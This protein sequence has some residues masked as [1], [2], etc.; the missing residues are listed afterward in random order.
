MYIV[1]HT[2]YMYNDYIKIN[3]IW[4]MYMYNHSTLPAM[5][6]HPRTI[7]VLPKILTVVVGF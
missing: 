7:S 3:H 5:E 6:T 2:N 4:Y 1:L